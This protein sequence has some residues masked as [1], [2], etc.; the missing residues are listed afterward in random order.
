MDRFELIARGIAI[1]LLVVVF[2]FCFIDMSKEF[3]KLDEYKIE[4]EKIELYSVVLDD[5]VE[6]RF[7]L[8][9]GYLGNK[10][11]FV[12]YRVL[13]DGGKAIYKM[14]ANIS[15]IYDTLESGESAY[16]EK[17]TKVMI[18]GSYPISY[19]IYVPQGTITQ[20]YDLSLK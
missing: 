10:Q 4:T 20:E 13:E 7:I 19:K 2:A 3:K 5:G 15:V 1:A 17:E 8:G 9:S 6:G 12:A 18:L 11:Y 14:D 16:V